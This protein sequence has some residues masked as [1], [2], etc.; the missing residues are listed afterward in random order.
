MTIFLRGCDKN[1]IR[2]LSLRFIMMKKTTFYAF[3]LVGF[4]SICQ[5]S[6]AQDY[7]TAI[8]AK[9][10]GYENGLSVKYF[11]TTDV[12]I[13]GILG[14]RQHG[15]VVTGFIEGNV[16]AFKVSGL[17][18]FY[19]GGGHVG[20]TGTGVYENFDGHKESYNTGHVL[21][22]IDA[23]VGFEYIIPKTPI[24]ISIDLDPRVEL[25]ASPFFDVAPALGLKYTF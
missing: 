18:F 16:Q 19:G 24:A 17:K 20:G 25:T 8:G 4:L 5:R 7:K 21:L 22:G 13:E 2:A 14:F 11:T 3:I 9:F 23:A 10:G 12:A 15:V 6:A 1:K